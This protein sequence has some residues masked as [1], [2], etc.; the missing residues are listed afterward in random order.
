MAEEY[1]LQ[2]KNIQKEYYGN[3]VLKGVNLSVN[4]GEIHGLIGENGAGK[5]TLMNILFGMPVI[6]STGGYSGNV[7]INSKKV[8]IKSPFEAMNMGI[9]MV[10][11]EFMLIPNFTITENIKLNR[12]ITQDNLISKVFKSERLKTLNSSAMAED[13]RKALNRVG[14]NIDEWVTIAGLPVGYMQFIEIARE[15]DKTGIKLLVFDEPTAVLAESEAS[16]L[17]S[18]MKR[19]AET[20]IAI[21]FITHRLSEVISAA[22][23]ITVLRDGELVAVKAKKDTD[24]I[25]LAEIMVG[26]KI[27]LKGKSDQSREHKDK[28]VIL[29]IKNLQVDMPGER[30]NEVDLSI[31]KGEI[32]GIGGLAGQGKVG[33]ANGI[34][35][36]YPSKGEVFFKGEKLDLNNTRGAINKGLAFV[37]EDRR[38][39]GLLLDHSLELNIVITA[40]QN[41]GKF[42]KRFGIFSQLDN[43]EIR[44]Y[45]NK[46]IRDLDIRCIRPQQL[47]RQLSGGNQQKVCVARALTL[48]PEVLFVSEPTRG[49]DIGAKKLVLDLLIKLNTE[50]GMT[51]IMTSSE[52]VELRSICDRIAIISNGKV[53][54][55]LKPSNSDR[56]FGLMMAGEYRRMQQEEAM[57][58]D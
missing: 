26:R 41:K 3:K 57:I 5:S 14:L 8:D 7:Y 17:I 18:A 29:E 45:T 53:E 34:M 48:N 38:G 39:M 23:N 16:N 2:M 32:F 9:G 37:S 1:V 4:K 58:N 49:I 20:G 47:T 6:H 15:I 11:Q 19:L 55:I 21:L 50:L 52:L 56:E 27:D 54:G 51:I 31:Y 36:L 12:E 28:E 46:M 30:V 44:E 43:K 25:E 13:A 42:L 10:H 33:I 40:M 22:D 24:V 35:G